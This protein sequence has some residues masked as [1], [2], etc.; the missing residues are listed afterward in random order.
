VH[1]IREKRLSMEAVMPTAKLS[2]R[3]ELDDTRLSRAP[4]AWV[5]L[6]AWSPLLPL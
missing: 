6:P 3:D 1:G 2:I 5:V 4:K